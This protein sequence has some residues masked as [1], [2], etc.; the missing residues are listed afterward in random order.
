ME[1]SLEKLIQNGQM[2]KTKLK[3]IKNFKQIQNQNYSNNKNSYN[4]NRD[5]II[6]NQN[7][8]FMK[9]RKLSKIILYKY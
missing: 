5:Q 3:N 8:T 1:I 6:Q 9:I 7:F 2:K 4:R